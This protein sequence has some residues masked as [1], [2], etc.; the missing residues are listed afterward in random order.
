MIRHPDEASDAS[1]AVILTTRA[2]RGEEGP[3]T[4][5][6]QR[7]RFRFRHR[8]A[9]LILLSPRKRGEFLFGRQQPK[10]GTGGAC[11]PLSEILPS[12]RVARFV[13]M[14]QEPPCARKPIQSGRVDRELIQIGR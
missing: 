11:A 8:A 4:A 9:L 13:R 10:T 1:H 6:R 2:S 3:R 5:S 14:T 7:S 12:A